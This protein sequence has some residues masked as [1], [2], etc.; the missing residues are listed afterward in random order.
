MK[1]NPPKRMEYISFSTEATAMQDGGLCPLDDEV[2]R[3]RMMHD[4]GVGALLRF[5]V[6]ALGQTDVV[7]LLRMQNREDLGLVLEIRA[8]RIA[9]GIA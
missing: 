5:E 1:F 8:G 9:E 2:L 6:K 7:V 4:D 3:L